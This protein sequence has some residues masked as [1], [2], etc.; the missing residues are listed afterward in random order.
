ME[1]EYLFN[2]YYD[3]VFVKIVT[4][5]TRWEAV[6]LVCSRYPELDRSKFKAKKI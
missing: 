2:V 3:K 1:R 4:A 5:H 6:E